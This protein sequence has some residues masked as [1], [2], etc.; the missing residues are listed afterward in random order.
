MAGI[1]LL[2]IFDVS[3]SLGRNP[4]KAT[5][6]TVAN[7]LVTEYLTK[8]GGGF[9]YDPA[10][11]ATFELFRGAISRSE[12][13]KLCETRGNPKGWR[14]NAEAVEAVADYA[15]ANKS[16]CY[17]IRF[18]A[19]EAGRVRG[20]TVYV[21]IKAPL[22]RVRNREAFV[23]VPGYRMSHRPIEIEIDV[24]C[25]I[26]LAHLA[27]D[28]YSGADFEYLY[29]GPEASGQRGFRAIVGRE[30]HIFDRDAVDALLEIYVKGIDL[31]A[32]GGVDLRSPRLAGYRIVDDDQPGMFGG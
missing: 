10:I 3:R 12:A 21:G 19:V 23:V 17:R 11:R 8:Q 14:Q 22:V 13:I 20:H 30:R 26:A 24:A 2:N 4:L 16:E 27:R 1:R 6:E 28:D 32:S 5:P 18:T 9:N 29:A 15:L 7:W 31:V 25:S